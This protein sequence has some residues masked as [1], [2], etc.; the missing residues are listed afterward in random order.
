MRT[1]FA[2]NFR[3]RVDLLFIHFQNKT[4]SLF[5]I[6]NIMAFGGRKSLLA[7]LLFLFGT[8]CGSNNQSTKEARIGRL[9]SLA[10]HSDSIG[11]LNNS[12]KYYSQALKIDSTKLVALINRGRALVSLGKVKEGLDDYNKA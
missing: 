3:N 1:D 6:D 5:Q 7:I 10:V 4:I 12:V 11:D 8:G 2:E 9:V